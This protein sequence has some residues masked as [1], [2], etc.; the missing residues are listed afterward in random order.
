MAFRPSVRLSVCDLRYCGNIGWNT[1]K[2]I[3]WMI[4]RL[5]S[6]CIPQR[7]GSTLKGTP[8]NFGR[9]RRGVD[10]A[11]SCCWRFVVSHSRLLLCSEC[12]IITIEQSLNVI[13]SN[14]F[15]VLKHYWSK[16]ALHRA[17]SLRHR[18]FLVDIATILY[19]DRDTGLARQ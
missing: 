9:N 5:S 18:G 11:T 3:S 14:G 16:N 6:L 12:K 17:V 1:T 7:H 19:S 15:L 13:S 10:H 4:S 2:I 8:R